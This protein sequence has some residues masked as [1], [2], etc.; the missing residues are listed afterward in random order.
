MTALLAA[1]SAGDSAAGEQL[2]PVIYG[3]LR[4]RAAAHLRDERGDHT[5]QPTALVHE[6]YL[7]LLGQDATWQNRAHFFAVS[8]RLMRR[9]LLDH[10]R[11]AGRTKRFGG[12]IRLSIDGL[13][14]PDTPV[15]MIDCLAID[16]ALTRLS[17]FD[18]RK[19]RIAELRFF[20]GLSTPETARSCSRS[21]W[22]GTA[23]RWRQS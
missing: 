8:A 9:V 11:R 5:L 18:Q 10:A 23:V 21:I 3:E 2:F 7:R 6:V 16:A 15:A 13:A 20:A 4:R 1:W 19:A 12:C 22:I 17:S 14:A